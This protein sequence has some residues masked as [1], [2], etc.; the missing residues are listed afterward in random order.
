MTAHLRPQIGFNAPVRVSPKSPREAVL[1]AA[2]AVMLVCALVGCAAAKAKH[3]SSV[4]S[5][6]SSSASTATSSQTAAVEAAAGRPL[7]SGFLGLSMQYKS[8]EGY[9]GTNAK[10]VNPAF[11]NLIRDIAPNQSPILRFGG[12]STDWTWWPVKGMPKP[13]GIRY[14]LNS[15]WLQ[16]ARAM[17]AQLHSRLILGVNLEAGSVKLAKTMA[18]ALVSG[19]G[20]PSIAGL[21]IGNEPELYAAFNWYTTKSGTGVPGRNKATWNTS[22]F[23]K[24]FRQFAAAMPSGVP[25]A[26][27][28]SG[29]VTW[30]SKLG[31][32]LQGQPRLKLSTF[33]AYPLKHC[34]KHVVTIPQ[35]LSPAA[36]SGFAR[37]QAQYVT[38][39][40]HHGKRAQLDEINGITCG[41]YGGVSDSFA[42][43]LWVLDTLFELDRIGVDGVNIQTVPGGAQ[44]IFGPLY[45]DG[46][47]MIVRPEFYGL[48]MFA[49]A[50]P[51]GS[52]LFTIPA[53]LPANVK[54]W[55]TR[56][57]DGTVHV[58]L[59]N[60]DL[61][62]ARTIHVPLS[63]PGGPAAVEALRAPHV[64]STGGVTLG[65]RSFGKSTST[66]ILPAPVPQQLQATGGGYNVRIPPAT[67]M[68]LTVPASAAAPAS[69]ST[70]SAN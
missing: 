33:H 34:T 28:A 35:L 54:M 66:G 5:S 56:A 38:T 19:I 21:E 17:N 29:S 37:A 52:R 25:V 57:K 16:I 68:L 47:S 23:A 32:F 11:L 4:S 50:A 70:A 8:F 62:K 9:A 60:D 51:A 63:S 55:P 49:Q 58:T 65:G 31:A 36:T 30:L 6:S 27:P 45:G 40:H 20:K 10:A 41:G 67:A 61:S 1:R 12:D 59:I 53:K 13:G 7:P 48:M 42:S 43:A 26:G 69:S 3:T 24:Q 2:I 44:E 22:A 15:K 39:A 64:A 46:G 18:N 14:T